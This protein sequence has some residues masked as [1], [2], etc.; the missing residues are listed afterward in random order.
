MTSTRTALELI[1]TINPL[2]TDDVSNHETK[3]DVVGEHQKDD[4][5]VASSCCNCYGEHKKDDDVVAKA[6]NF[7]VFN[8]HNGMCSCAQRL[9][10]H[11]L[12]ATNDVIL[13]QERL[14]LDKHFDQET[15]IFSGKYKYM[16]IVVDVFFA[17]LKPPNLCQSGAPKWTYHGLQMVFMLFLILENLRLLF[18]PLCVEST[19]IFTESTSSYCMYC[20]SVQQ[21]LHQSN[22]TRN[23]TG[24]AGTLLSSVF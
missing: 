19:F 10:S 14:R 8:A 13:C 12:T 15:E 16:K 4:D 24:Y 6:T 9:C 5:V 20:H 3:I 23:I 11:G 18:R 7:P 2:E 21:Q 1:E 22:Y 17:I